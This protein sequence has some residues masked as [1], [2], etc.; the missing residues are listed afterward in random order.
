MYSWEVLFSGKHSV[1]WLNTSC[2]S[3]VSISYLGL[4]NGLNVFGFVY[5]VCFHVQV[6][7]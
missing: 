4:Y 7:T 1:T 6:A 3:G 2:Y 5:I